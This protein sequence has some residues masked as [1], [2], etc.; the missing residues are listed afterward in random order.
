M[1]IAVWVCLLL[2]A[3]GVHAA[4]GAKQPPNIVL[5]VAD[6]LGYADLGVYGSTF[7]ETPNLDRLA[8]QGVRFS[9]AYAAAPVCSPTRACIMTGK[10][11]ARV[12][13]TDYIPGGSRGK[14]LP[15]PFTQQ[16]PPA[17]TNLA[18]SLKAAGY[19]TWHVGKWHLG[20]E[21]F[22]PQHQGFDVNVAGGSA[23]TARSGFFSPYKLPNLSDGPEG[24][25]LTDRLT[26]EAIKLIESQPKDKPFFLNLWH[27]A[28]HIPIQAPEPIVEKYRTK[29][30]KLGLNGKD[31]M[32]PGEPYPIEKKR[33][34]RVTRRTV[35]SDPV[36]A[37]M[38]ENLDTNVGRL[39]ELIEKSGRA[40]NTVVVFTSDNGGVSTSEGSPTCNAPLRDGKGF[41]YEG[42]IRVPLIIKWP[43]SK[44]PPGVIY[45]GTATSA[46]LMPTLLEM[47]GAPVLPDLDGDSLAQSLRNRE[48]VYRPRFWHYPHYGNQGGTPS[49]AI[50]HGQWKLIEFFEDGRLELYDLTN[51]VGET[52][53]LAKQE[54][55]RVNELHGILTAWR[56]NVGAK[57]PTPNPTFAADPVTP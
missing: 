28:P 51:D 33:D 53:D 47:A 49:G 55:E 48:I 50:R 22:F 27:Y 36:Y 21:P 46:D 32:V 4:D 9:D 52:K 41:L 8:S 11:P 3:S 1:R 39:L 43:G 6:D 30:K 18:E 26:D 54:P 45:S 37:A 2:I 20:R 24:E 14:L 40:D 13:V 35:Q 15:A 29:A 10:H 44:I 25:Y 7:Y 31:I 12:G 56:K 17:E 42:G 23:G 38:I 19:A 57:M 16:L 5:I 34:K